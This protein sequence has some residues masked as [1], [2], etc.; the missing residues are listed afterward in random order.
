M[1][2][3]YLFLPLIFDIKCYDASYESEFGGLPVYIDFDSYQ[4]FTQNEISSLNQRLSLS[5][6]SLSDIQKQE[7]NRLGLVF[8]D[9][10]KCQFILYLKVHSNISI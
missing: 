7:L 5:N 2:L 9:W 3:Q 6:V 8:G 1:K 4:C 10:S